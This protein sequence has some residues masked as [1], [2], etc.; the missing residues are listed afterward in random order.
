MNLLVF[1]ALDLIESQYGRIKTNN[2]LKERMHSKYNN[3]TYL[4][5]LYEGN[6]GMLE[7]DVYGYI[8]NTKYKYI[9]I[10]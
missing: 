10:K 8:S 4:G 3:S 1:Q 6:V 2:E 9:V 7:L 5:L